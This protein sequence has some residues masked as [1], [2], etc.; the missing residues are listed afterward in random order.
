MT[1]R[2]EPDGGILLDVHGSDG[3]FVRAFLERVGHPVTTCSGP[4]PGLI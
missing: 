2:R 1:T 3:E 4:E